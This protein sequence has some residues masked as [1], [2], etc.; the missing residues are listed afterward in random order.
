MAASIKTPV[1]LDRDLCRLNAI[2]GGVISE[3]IDTLRET[4]RWIA[5]HRPARTV[6]PNLAH[7]KGESRR[8]VKTI[9]NTAYQS[10]PY[11]D[12]CSSLS[13]RAAQIIDP[14]SPADSRKNPRFCELHDPTRKESTHRTALRH[15]PRFD[16]LVNAIEKEL[17]L[18]MAFRT[19]FVDLAWSDTPQA[20]LEDIL[21]L[22]SGAEEIPPD[23]VEQLIRHYAFEISRKPPDQLLLH[24]ARFSKDGM[25]PAD[26]AKTL[27]MSRQAVCQRIGNSRGVFDFERRSPLLQWWPDDRVTPEAFSLQRLT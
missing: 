5:R 13:Q 16:A 20:S 11:C 22:A 27:N 9:D 4:V 6:P 2:S 19:R 15:K 25:I 17:R 18:D 1:R 26:I 23:P 7:L 21:E 24:I 12:H 3:T 8:S 10:W 14:N